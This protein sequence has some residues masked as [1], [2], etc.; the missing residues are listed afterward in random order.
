MYFKYKLPSNGEI[1]IDIFDTKSFLNGDYNLPNVSVRNIFKKG[2][3]KTAF[4]KIFED[5]KGQYIIWNKEHIYLKD[6]DFMSI[7][8]LIHKI[9]VAVKTN[10]HWILHEDDI[11]ASLFINSDKIGFIDELSCFETI[12]PQIGI[13]ITGSK[14]QEVLCKLSERL[15]AKDRWKYKITL[16]PEDEKLLGVVADRTYYFSDFCNLIMRGNIRVVNLDTYKD[17]IEPV[18]V[19]KVNIF[20][21]IV[22]KIFKS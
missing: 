21:R 10:K 17:E 4:K 14:K 7:D 13:G 20:K 22:Q 11:L 9:D 15:Y 5:S 3:G 12:I 2:V 18:I 1:E 6:F 16:V 8:Q 19:E